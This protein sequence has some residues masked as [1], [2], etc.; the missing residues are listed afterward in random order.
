MNYKLLRMLSDGEFHSGVALGE[1]LGLTRAA[2]WKNVAQLEQAGIEIESVKGRG[3]RLREPIAMLSKELVCSAIKDNERLGLRDFLLLDSVD[4]TNSYLKSHSK[5][6]PLGS[7]DVCVAEEQT[8]G[9]GRRG[10]SWVSPIAKNLYVSISFRLPGGFSSLSGLSLALGAAT[11]EAI[12]FSAGL[13]AGLKWPNDVWV[14]G[15][16]ISGI[17]VDVEGEHNGPVL[18]VA[19]IGLNVS[20]SE[21]EATSI[22]QPWTSLERE[23]G[24]GLD[25]NELLSSLLNEVLN[26]IDL[27]MEGGFSAVRDLWESHDVLIGRSIRLLGYNNQIEGVYKGVDDMGNLL[28]ETADEG[29]AAYSAGEVSIRPLNDR[30]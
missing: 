24:R 12:N 25:R 8:G 7:Y 3:Y 10:R 29:V 13:S 18:V 20:M 6:L 15:K 2:I 19:G 27:F 30:V 23:V 4:S 11:A 16:K 21:E 5:N 17:L 22:D 9:R 28:M 26:S 1:S 14:A